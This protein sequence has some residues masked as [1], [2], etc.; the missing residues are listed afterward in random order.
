V[1]SGECS[2]SLVWRGLLGLDIL[3]VRLVVRMSL[4]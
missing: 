3:L 2:N 4:R 1:A